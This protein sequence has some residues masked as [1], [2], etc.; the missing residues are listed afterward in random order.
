MMARN[1]LTRFPMF[2][3]FVNGV[4]L[5]RIIGDSINTCKAP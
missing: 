2:S 3:C 1:N 5:D 4:A